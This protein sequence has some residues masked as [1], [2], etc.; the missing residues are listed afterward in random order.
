MRLVMTDESGYSGEGYFAMAGYVADQAMWELFDRLWV[1]RLAKYSIDHFHM[2]D[3]AHRKGH[4]DGWEEP[5]RVALMSD[6]LEVIT[7]GPL[8]AIGACLRIANFQA[9]NPEIQQRF[10][11]PYLCCFQ[12]MVFGSGLEVS[13]AFPGERVDFLYSRQDDF[14]SKMRSI[15]NFKKETSDYG[16]RL[17]TLTFRDMR[18]APGLQ[19][20]DLLVYEFRHY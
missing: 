13:E 5:R 7:A 15:W 10:V 14:K 12:E 6:L 19:A 9:L 3:F 17:G 18:E 16:K 2:K 20:A 8:T 4:F 1:H 11:A